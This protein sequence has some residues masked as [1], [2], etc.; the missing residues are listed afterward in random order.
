MTEDLTPD[1][2]IDLTGSKLDEFGG[3][4]HCET[5]LSILLENFSKIMHSPVT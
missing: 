4:V 1:I 3:N 5:S 2:Y